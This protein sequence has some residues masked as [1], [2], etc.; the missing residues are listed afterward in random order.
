MSKFDVNYDYY[1]S[2]LKTHFKIESLFIFNGKYF[3]NWLIYMT[4]TQ[5]KLF[6]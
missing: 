5:F 4:L 1:Y 2:Y 6:V 3:T